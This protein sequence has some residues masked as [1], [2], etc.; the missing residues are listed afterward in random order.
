M[1]CILNFFVNVFVNNRTYPILQKTDICNVNI[2]GFE[3]LKE[4]SGLW[5]RQAKVISSYN[6]IPHSWNRI[7]VSYITRIYNTFCINLTPY[8]AGSESDKPLPPVESQVSLHGPCS[9]TR[10]YT[11]GWPTSNS[12]LDISKM[13][14]N[15]S[16]NGMR[17]IQF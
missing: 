3:A 15:S 16:K 6:Y 1:L 8:P 5:K 13:I 10:V 12:H 17:I 7:T 2:C 4:M 11:I 9:L 14:M